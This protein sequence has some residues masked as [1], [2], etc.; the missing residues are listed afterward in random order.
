MTGMRD[1]A[2][3]TKNVTTTH[4]LGSC[5]VASQTHLRKA[6]FAPKSW[7]ASKFDMTPSVTKISNLSHCFG[8]SC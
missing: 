2:S 4:G 6:F 1:H 8:F 5:E 3:E 7:A